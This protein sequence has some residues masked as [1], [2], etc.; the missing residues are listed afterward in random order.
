MIIR[1]GIPSTTITSILRGQKLRGASLVLSSLG[2]SS[3]NHSWRRP[4]AY[5]DLLLSPPAT[6]ALWVLLVAW[7][8]TG[9]Y[10][11]GGSC[12][13][14]LC[15]I[16][17]IAFPVLI[18]IGVLNLLSIISFNWAFFLLAFLIILVAS[19]VPELTWKVTFI[20]FKTNRRVLR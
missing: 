6:G 20:D 3:N 12:G 18:I 7:I 4:I 11:N 17:G 2:S 1:H 15:K 8:G 10:F 9:C 16:D 19:F 13:R 5:Q 14:V